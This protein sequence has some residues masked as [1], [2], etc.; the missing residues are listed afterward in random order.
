MYNKHYIRLDANNHIIKG[1]SDAFEEPLE[2]DICITEEGGRH[3]ELFDTINPPI[4][5]ITGCHLFKYVNNNVLETT[6]EER[7]IEFASLPKDVESS[8]LE[9]YLID[10]DFRL[11]LIELGV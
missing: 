8:Q 4:V 10:L 6:E 5:D 3:F 7:A 11:S 2:T 9:E 1:F